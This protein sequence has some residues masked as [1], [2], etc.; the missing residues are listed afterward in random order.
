M[1]VEYRKIVFVGSNEE[2]SRYVIPGYSREVD[3]YGLV[4]LPGMHDVHMHAQEASNPVTGTSILP[5]NKRC[6]EKVIGNG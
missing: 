1:V 2:A 5:S 3:L 6:G 4:V